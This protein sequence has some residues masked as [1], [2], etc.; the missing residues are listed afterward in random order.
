MYRRRWQGTANV[1]GPEP[2]LPEYLG[3]GILPRGAHESELLESMRRAKLGASDRPQKELN[4]DVDAA[5]A[6]IK[7]ACGSTVGREQRKH[8][9][10]SAPLRI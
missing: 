7:W 3:L 4:R 9:R 1:S 5:A 2:S 8:R 10:T 6:Y